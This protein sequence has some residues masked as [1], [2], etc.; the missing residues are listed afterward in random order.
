MKNTLLILTIVTAALGS[1]NVKLAATATTASQPTSKLNI[2]DASKAALCRTAKIVAE[3]KNENGNFQ[4]PDSRIY[5]KVNLPASIPAG[6]DYFVVDANI[7]NFRFL[8]AGSTILVFNDEVFQLAPKIGPF[9]AHAEN[10]P[11]FSAKID[12]KPTKDSEV[13]F[14]NVSYAIEYASASGCPEAAQ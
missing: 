1:C 7:E 9:K 6:T 12:H 10:T 4:D 13:Q 8:D 2:S 5:A 11:K 14:L 3:T